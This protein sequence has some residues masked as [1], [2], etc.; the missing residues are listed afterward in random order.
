MGPADKLLNIDDPE[1]AESGRRIAAH[2]GIEG[3]I[4]VDVIRDAQ[5]RDW[6]HD[7]NPR[8]WGSFAAFRAAGVDFLGA[9]VDWLRGVPQPASRPTNQG[10]THIDVYPAAFLRQR[11]S[12]HRAQVQARLT[13][14]ALPYLKW[15]GPRYVAY[16]LA[17]NLKQ[18]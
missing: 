12:E 1:L 10:G 9:Y 18:K 14:A 11:P 5:G 4:N 3:M 7:V 8:V 6:V 16:E 15:V 2:L 13:R 17:H